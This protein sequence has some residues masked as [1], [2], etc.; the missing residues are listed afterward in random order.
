MLTPLTV[1]PKTA[2]T[3]QPGKH[4]CWCGEERKM[5]QSAQDH[6]TRKGMATF[7]HTICLWGRIATAASPLMER[8]MSQSC[9]SQDSH[10]VLPTPT[11]LRRALRSGRALNLSR[12]RHLNHS[13]PPRFLRSLCHCTGTSNWLRAG[14]S[15]TAVGSYWSMVEFR[16]GLRA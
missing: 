5:E 4:H 12:V 13:H 8:G 16:L 3:L 14:E 2:I 6:T 7:Q 1:S 15:E 9:L 11:R 10:P